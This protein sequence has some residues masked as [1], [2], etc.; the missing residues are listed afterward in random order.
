MNNYL[1]IGDNSEL[2]NF[3]LSDILKKI[4]HTDDD[5]IEYNLS[6]SSLSD[7]LD[8][9]LMPSMFS[10]TKII[11]GSSLDIS[12]LSDNDI[13][14]LN[15]YLNDT[16]ENNY[17]VL[18]TKKV[19]S[20]L[21]IYKPFKEHFKVIDT[22]KTNN[23]D[24]IV[25]YIKNYIKE[26]KYKINDMDIEYLISKTGNDINNI[27][28]E[29]SKLF[30]YKDSD[31]MITTTDIDLLIPDNIDNV[32]YEFTNAILEDDTDTIIKMYNNFKIE[33][34][35]FDYLISSIA[36]SFR[37]A[38]IIKMLHNSNESNLSISKTIGKKEFYVKKMLDRIYRYTEEDLCKYINRL[39]KIDENFKS[40]KANI[41]E[42]EFFLLNKDY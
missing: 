8:E 42:L 33:N 18:I 31:K 34:I 39:A 20:R 3:Y 14:Y 5:L 16:H 35:S 1:L 25:L 41:D 2:V 7:V 23:K 10:T 26:N 37:Q 38:L 22:G 9:A 6:I 28:N 11:I 27:N 36:N 32:I 15:N 21:S 13:E 30:I 12:K 24:D 29:L 19:D 4:D 17:I 40:G